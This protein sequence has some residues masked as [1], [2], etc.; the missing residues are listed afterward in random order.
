MAQGCE[1][2]SGLRNLRGLVWKVA[3][4]LKAFLGGLN[5][6]SPPGASLAFRRKLGLQG[7]QGGPCL[8]SVCLPP[9]AP[10]G[11]RPCPALLWPRCPVLRRCLPACTTSCPTTGKPSSVLCPTG[12]TVAR[13]KTQPKRRSEKLASVPGPAPR[14]LEA[15]AGA[16][17]VGA[18][19]EVPV[20]RQTTG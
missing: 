6:T 11:C 17:F 9:A 20:H 14:P 13:Y 2:D 18:F 15:A 12:S 8:L 5:M 16:G 4:V 19:P 3:P 7:L 10:S 1:R